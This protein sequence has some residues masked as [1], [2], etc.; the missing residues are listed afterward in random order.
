[1]SFKYKKESSSGIKNMCARYVREDLETL[2]NISGIT[3]DA[4]TQLDNLPSQY[5]KD[6]SLFE[7]LPKDLKSSEERIAFIQSKLNS[8]QRTKAIQNATPLAVVN[9][10][11]PASSYTNQAWDNT[12]NTP[13]THVGYIIEE[14]GKKY[15]IHLNGTVSAKEPLE[16]F[17]DNTGMEIIGISNNSDYKDTP[18]V[19]ASSTETQNKI[20]EPAINNVPVQSTKVTENQSSIIPS[21]IIK[22]SIRLTTPDFTEE[23]NILFSKK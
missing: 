6:Y 8:E 21:D 11:N 1:M 23:Y 10:F 5:S 12:K 19:L 9:I 22:K 15:V 4:W 14:E 17:Y 18:N 16:N 3:G 2:Y 13:G 7:E 20:S